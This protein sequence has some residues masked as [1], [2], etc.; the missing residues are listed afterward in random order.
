MGGCFSFFLNALGPSESAEQ[1]LHIA[2]S[3]DFVY[4]LDTRELNPCNMLKPLRMGVK[5]SWLEKKNYPSWN[6]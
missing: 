2:V 4:V 6:P 1:T 5:M 3:T